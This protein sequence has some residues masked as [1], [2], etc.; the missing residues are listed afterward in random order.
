MRPGLEGQIDGI[1]PRQLSSEASRGLCC[2]DWYFIAQSSSCS[3]RVWRCLLEF[4]LDLRAAAKI[5][6]Q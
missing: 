2:C 6:G 5:L 4:E 1:A 3:R